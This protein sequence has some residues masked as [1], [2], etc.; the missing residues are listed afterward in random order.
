MEKPFSFDL[1]ASGAHPNG[2]KRREEKVKGGGGVGFGKDGVPE[3]LYFF[4]LCVFSWGPDGFWMLRPLTRSGPD[5]FDDLF[6]YPISPS[7]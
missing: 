7:N 3:F 2:G 5:V 4:G 1:N 6:S